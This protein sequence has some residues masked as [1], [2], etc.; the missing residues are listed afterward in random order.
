MTAMLSKVKRMIFIVFLGLIAAIVLGF[1]SF[2]SKDSG[3]KIEHLFKSIHGAVNYR[4]IE[5]VRELAKIGVGMEEEDEL[6]ATPLITATSSDQFIIAEIL[7][8]HGANIWSHTRFGVTAPRMTLK[9]LTPDNSDEG[10]ARLRLIERFKKE[11][12]PW[13]PPD[14]EEV[15]RLVKTQAWPTAQ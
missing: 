14:R 5:A 11:N 1:Y 7:V 2:N 12:Y 4:D 13:P 15:L 9:S 10:M 3:T 8:Q 6:G